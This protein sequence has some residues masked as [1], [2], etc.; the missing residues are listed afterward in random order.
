ME[1]QALPGSYQRLLSGPT[2]LVLLADPESKLNP[3]AENL[4]LR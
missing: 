4:S 1:K 2:I 3:T